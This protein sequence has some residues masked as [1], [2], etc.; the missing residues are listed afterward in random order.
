MKIMLL[1]LAVSTAL[2]MTSQTL[3]VDGKEIYVKS[4]AACH[5]ALSLRLSD[6]AVWEP[7]IKQ[8]AD[9]LVASVLKGKGAMPAK[10]GNATLSETDIRA[11][12]DYMLTQ[13]K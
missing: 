5:T 6:K 12:V 13:L 1:G 3:A 8:G 10:G 11:A 4:C 9:A 2:L 7:R